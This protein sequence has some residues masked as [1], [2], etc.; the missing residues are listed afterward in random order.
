MPTMVT[1]QKAK[2]RTPFVV[3][4]RSNSSMPSMMISVTSFPS[5]AKLKFPIQSDSKMLGPVAEA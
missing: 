5:Y 3:G 4:L 2:W 1:L